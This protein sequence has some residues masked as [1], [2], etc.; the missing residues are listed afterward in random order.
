MMVLAK[1]RGVEIEAIEKKNE[2]SI[3]CIRL[4]DF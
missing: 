2:I 1:M 3:I 4:V